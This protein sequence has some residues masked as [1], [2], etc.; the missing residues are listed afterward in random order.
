MVFG[1]YI[2]IVSTMY[3]TKLECE[4]ESKANIPTLTQTVVLGSQ[5]KI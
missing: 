4:L 5:I 2:A 1:I 3:L